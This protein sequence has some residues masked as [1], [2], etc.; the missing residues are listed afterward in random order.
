MSVRT[1]RRLL[2][3]AHA[4]LIAVI[5]YTTM[6][7]AVV[8]DDPDVLGWLGMALLAYLLTLR[9]N[10]LPRWALQRL[11]REARCPECGQGVDLVNLWHCGCG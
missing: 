10:P 3:L 5:A 4:G 1:R 7:I 9:W 6:A 11:I 8:C 2:A